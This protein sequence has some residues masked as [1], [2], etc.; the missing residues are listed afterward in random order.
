MQLHAH[1]VAKRLQLT[2]PRLDVALDSLAEITHDAERKQEAGQ[3]STPH[4]RFRSAKPMDTSERAGAISPRTLCRA[5]RDAR[6]TLLY[7]VMWPR[8]PSPD[9]RGFPLRR[10]L[11]ALAF[12]SDERRHGQAFGSIFGLCNAEHGRS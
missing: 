8:E 7:P 9:P 3:P 10:V 11:H 2:E 1:F 4:V 5:L 12:R 6:G